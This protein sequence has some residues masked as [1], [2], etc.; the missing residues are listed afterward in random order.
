VVVPNS[1]VFGAAGVDAGVVVSIDAKTSGLEVSS[2]SMSASLD[3]GASMLA[4]LAKS[5]RA[6]PKVPPKNEFFGSFEVSGTS[7]FAFGSALNV[8]P[9]TK[10]PDP[11][12]GLLSNIFVAPPNTL[13]LFIKESPLGEPKALFE[14]GLEP[15]MLPVGLDAAAAVAKPPLLAN[16]ANPDAWAG[17][18]VAE[19]DAPKTED[20][21]VRPPAWPKAAFG[22]VEPPVAQGEARFPR[23]KV[24]VL[25]VPNDGVPNAG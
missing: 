22:A 15:N 13:P 2:E 19:P 12:V 21:L 25:V 8:E 24:G 18:L 17:V 5:P 7:S 16:A 14:A 23:P 10:P 3:I 11:K 4:G 1:W 20:G 9:R 6:L